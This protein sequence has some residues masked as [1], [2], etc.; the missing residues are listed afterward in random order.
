MANLGVE[1]SLFLY[2]RNVQTLTPISLFVAPHGVAPCQEDYETSVHS[3]PKRSI[4][5]DSKDSRF[6]KPYTRRVLAYSSDYPPAKQEK[7]RHGKL[8]SQLVP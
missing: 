1:P 7:L 8:P 2:E 5:Q 3:T 6:L 4:H